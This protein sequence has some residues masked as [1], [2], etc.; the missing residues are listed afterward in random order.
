MVRLL[1]VN[2]KLVFDYV[3]KLLWCCNCDHLQE[4]KVTESIVDQNKNQH[5]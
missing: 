3:S 2:S 1:T 5:A 4:F